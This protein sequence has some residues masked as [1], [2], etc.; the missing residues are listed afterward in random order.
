[1]LLLRHSALRSKANTPQ[2]GPSSSGVARFAARYDRPARSSRMRFRLKTSFLTYAHDQIRGG[3]W[4][5]PTW[6]EAVQKVPPTAVLPRLKKK[7]IPRLR[8]IEDKLMREFTARNPSLK[9]VDERS[10]AR[11]RTSSVASEFVAEQLQH[12]RADTSEPQSFDVASR[13]LVENGRRVLR[14]V[15]PTLVGG[16]EI[17]ASVLPPQD[18]FHKVLAIQS[19]LLKNALD[20]EEALRRGQRQRELPPHRTFLSTE[21]VHAIGQR[22]A[23]R[24]DP[25]FP[26]APPSP[27][28]EYDELDKRVFAEQAAAAGAGA[29]STESVLDS[30]EAQEEVLESMLQRGPE[31]GSAGGQLR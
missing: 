28:Y 27:E 1:L 8:F 5:K 29:D 4:Y 12:M 31:P 20:E 15:D 13:W 23:R 25:V 19:E 22:V 2:A 6:W 14:K 3:L 7:F 16:A 9:H 21:E 30:A 26:V 17:D 24:A 11:G 10:F 18:V